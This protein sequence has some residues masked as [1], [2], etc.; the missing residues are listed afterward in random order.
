MFTPK[1]MLKRKERPRSRPTSPRGEFRAVIGDDTVDPAKV[2]T[3]LLVSGRLT[4]DLVVERQ[5]SNREDVAI[6]RVEQLYPW[7]VEAIKAELAKYPQRQGQVVQDEPYN[8]GPW[9][10]YYL[11]VVPHLDREIEPVTRAA[12]S[13]TAVGTAK[14]HLEEAK[15]LIGEAF[16]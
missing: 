8:Q 10:S 6:L 5:K 16:A 11:N 13:T 14:R 9:P 12:S 1:S 4:W 7:P 2:T 3:V 15:V